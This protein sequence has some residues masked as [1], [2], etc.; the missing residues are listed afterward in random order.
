MTL[1]CRDANAD[2]NDKEFAKEGRPALTGDEL[3]NAPG[4]SFQ[5][6]RKALAA[7][8]PYSNAAHT[9]VSQSCI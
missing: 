5:F 7:A 8:A 2:P 3:I 4:I 9:A 1:L 6:L